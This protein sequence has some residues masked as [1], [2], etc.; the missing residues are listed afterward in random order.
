MSANR[1]EMSV[2]ANGVG[3]GILEKGNLKGMV[4]EVASKIIEIIW[5]V[6]LWL[7]SQCHNG[8]DNFLL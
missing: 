2:T 6:H 4:R 5:Q 8:F 1:I 3:W 7:F